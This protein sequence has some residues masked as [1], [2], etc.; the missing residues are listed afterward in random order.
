MAP[1]NDQL[2]IGT[3]NA[4][5]HIF[6][7]TSVVSSP[8]DSILQIVQKIQQDRET[9]ERSIRHHQ[10]DD[11]GL[12]RPDPD[13]LPSSPVH[14]S[15]KT[16]DGTTD[17]IIRHAYGRRKRNT[18][19]RTFRTKRDLPQDMAS[20]DDGSIYKLVHLTSSRVLPENQEGSRVTILKP[21]K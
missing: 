12:V 21:I 15:E 10:I 4:T 2:W 3:G 6:S 18:F 8:S 11:E 20:T 16:L 17:K 14:S 1:I 19:G 5:I 7:V 9:F 13:I